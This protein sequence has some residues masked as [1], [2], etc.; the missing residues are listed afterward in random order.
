MYLRLVGH[1]HPRKAHIIEI[2]I[3]T[4][5]NVSKTVHPIYQTF[6]ISINQ[7]KA[8][9]QDL[10]SKNKAYIK[11][12]KTTNWHHYDKQ[13]NMYQNTAENDVNDQPN[14]IRTSS[15]FGNCIVIIIPYKVIPQIAATPQ[16]PTRPFR[17]R[18]FYPYL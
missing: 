12:L 5:T 10:Y 16:N 8:G 14:D 13:Q 3:R 2:L 9:Y 4:P 1:I 6:G 17:L 11:I 7:G 15:R 18:H